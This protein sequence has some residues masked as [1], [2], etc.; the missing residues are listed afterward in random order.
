MTI[1][2][3]VE[4]YGKITA[5]TTAVVV[6]TAF[7]IRFDGKF[8]EGNRKLEELNLR[9]G[10]MGIQV[11]QLKTLVSDRDRY[12]RWNRAYNARLKRLFNRSGLEY[13]EVE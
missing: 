6:A 9:V 1:A 10:Q 5:Y 7:L 12:E 4:K 2:S 3:W 11:E 13:E 8:N